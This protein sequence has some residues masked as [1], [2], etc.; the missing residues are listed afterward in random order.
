MAPCS[1]LTGLNSSGKS[2]IL[3]VLALFRQTKESVGLHSAG[4]KLN[5][6]YVRLGNASEVLSSYQYGESSM[7]QIG[8]DSPAGDITFYYKMS[9]SEMES[10]LLQF[11]S[12]K[13]QSDSEYCF[14][15][16]AEV[17]ESI[18]ELKE[19]TVY[20]VNDRLF[21]VRGIELES[22]LIREPG[23]DAQ[24]KKTTFTEDFDFGDPIYQRSSARSTAL[25]P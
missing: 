16:D 18:E 14:E 1:V 22:Q 20:K 17:T 21:T 5:G 12:F 7:I 13:I 10:D 24:Q 25:E 8:A 2:T 4:F 23:F 9:D 3:Q 15:L 11:T 19:F 6:D